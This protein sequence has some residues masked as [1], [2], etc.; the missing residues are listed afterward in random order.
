MGAHR[1]PKTS[2][3]AALRP[4]LPPR[5]TALRVRRA[6]GRPPTAAG[7]A[8][9]PRV[10]LS[11]SWAYRSRQWRSRPRPLRDLR[12]SPGFETTPEPLLPPHRKRRPRDAPWGL[13]LLSPTSCWVP[14]HTPAA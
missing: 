12:T 2:R 7:L 5:R 1:L 10:R 4:F 14:P 6:V 13:L 11:A 9:R 3:G 8:L